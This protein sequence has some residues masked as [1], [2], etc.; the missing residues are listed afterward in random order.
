MLHHLLLELVLLP[1]LGNSVCAVMRRDIDP[2]EASNWVVETQ[3]WA[4]EVEWE[5]SVALL[6]ADSPPGSA[7]THC[8]SREWRFPKMEGLKRVL[9]NRQKIC[10]IVEG[11]TYVKRQA[12]VAYTR[13]ISV[14]S[15]LTLNTEICLTFV[16]DFVIQS[17]IHSYM[18]V[19]V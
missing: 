4:A 15:S 10:E 16:K 12:L 17:N 2:L 9:K 14:L 3:R 18:V 6:E 11:L 7:W 1:R 8:R 19:Y 5:G 13:K